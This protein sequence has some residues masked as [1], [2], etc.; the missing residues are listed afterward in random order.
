MP[1]PE[2][3]SV[4]AFGEYLLAD[5][6]TSCTYDEAVELAEALGLSVPVSVIRELR[7]YGFEVG[8]R[9]VPKHVRGFNSN[10]HDRWSAY[11][12][13]GGSGWQQITGIAGQEG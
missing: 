9:P 4:E 10:S 11:P 13:H 6:R 7:T 5:D 1:A 2:H 12:N 3:A 8:E